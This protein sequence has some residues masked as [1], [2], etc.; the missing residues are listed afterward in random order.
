M[1][2]SSSFDF[3]LH[4][5]LTPIDCFVQ[6]ENMKNQFYLA[7]YSGNQKV[8]NDLRTRLSRRCVIWLLPHPSL[9]LPAT[10]R[11]TE[12]ERQLADGRR[13]GVGV[14]KEPNHMTA[15][16]PGPNHS[17]LSGSSPFAVRKMWIPIY[18]Y[19]YQKFI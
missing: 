8:L 1:L 13:G 3:R 11:K 18:N 17:K 6:S 12:K 15:V 10:H 19:L 16:K 7:V 9:P 5:S 4:F 2:N 14:W